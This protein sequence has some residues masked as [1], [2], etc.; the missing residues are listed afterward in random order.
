MRPFSLGAIVRFRAD[1]AEGDA[2]NESLAS[3]SDFSVAKSEQERP[4]SV[5]IP[6]ANQ[7]TE[8]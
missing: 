1:P 8:T 6:G 3:V 2:P 7:V 4:H 5:P